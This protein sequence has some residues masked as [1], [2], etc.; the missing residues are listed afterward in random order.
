ME[1]NAIS[2]EEFSSM[3]EIAS[4]KKLINDTCSKL[5]QKSRLESS[6]YELLLYLAL[7]I[8]D[9]KGACKILE[10]GTFDGINARLLVE[11]N[12]GIH[13][14][15]IDIP[16]LDARSGG[17]Y[18]IMEPSNDYKLLEQRF[19]KWTTDHMEQ[20]IENVSHSRIVYLEQP[21][22]SLHDPKLSS[23]IGNI[24][25][26]WIDGDHTYPQVSF[27]AAAAVSAWY[28]NP[29]V[30]ILMDDVA[31]KDENPSFQTIKLLIGDLDLK[32]VLIQKGPDSNS[33]FIAVLSSSP[34][35]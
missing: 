5:G 33:K 3:P 2:Y 7:K 35:F 20:R 8:T 13:V 18:A 16:S 17:T 24:D 26:F 9:Q 29:D 28:S 15:T 11:S 22:I 27:D 31:F 6:H 25:L 10:I 12:K 34:I 14:T 1:F 21:S 19:L 30:L 4:C 23:D 32:C